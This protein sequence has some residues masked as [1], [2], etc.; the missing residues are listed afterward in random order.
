MTELTIITPKTKDL[1]GFS[2]RRALPDIKKRAIGPFVFFDHMGPA[3][4]PAGQGIDVRPHPHIGLATV[5]YLFVGEFRHQESLGTDQMVYPGEVNL[6]IA[7]SG[8][9]HSERT[10]HNTRAHPHPM[11]GLQ[12]WVAL[13]VEHEQT[14]PD[15]QHVKADDLPKWKDDGV[16]YSLVVGDWADKSTTVTHFSP[17][18]YMILDVP[19]NTQ[20]TLHPAPT[21]HESGLYVVSGSIDL[22]GENI[23]SGRMILLPEDTETHLQTRHTSAKLARI[24]GVNLGHRHLWWNFVSSSK[25]KLD[26]AKEEWRKGQ[27]AGGDFSGTMF[28]LPLGDDQEF[29]PLPD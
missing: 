2:V 19:E 7:G 16:T 4:F 5:T 21:N 26:H 10:S 25:D 23:E 17:M 8:I 9:T 11:H 29:I 20:H 13:P 12:V 24:G 15:F 1:G 14:D 28:D 3:I 22:N 6:M 27:A 18:H